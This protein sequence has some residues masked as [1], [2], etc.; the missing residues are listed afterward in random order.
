[1][2]GQ[3]VGVGMDQAVFTAFSQ[4]LSGNNA[5]LVNA[6]AQLGELAKQPGKFNQ[7]GE[8]ITGC[9]IVYSWIVIF[10]HTP[11]QHW[12]WLYG[13]LPPYQLIN[14]LISKLGYPECLCRIALDRNM[15][16][17]ERQISFLPNSH[18]NGNLIY[19]NS[20]HP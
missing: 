7:G 16:M 15:S 4:I 14:T 13:Y 12:S 18:V 1:M 8:S 6:E 17:A 2:L 11:T 20:C 10:G 5:A 19:S 9:A 3:F